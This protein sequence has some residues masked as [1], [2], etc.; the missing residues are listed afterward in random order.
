ML[1]IY[2][3]VDGVIYNINKCALDIASEEFGLT[4]EWEKNDDWWWQG[5]NMTDTPPPREYF[6]KLLNRKGFFLNGEAVDGAIKGV[7]EL[8]DYGFDIKFITAPHWSS[9]Y[10][11]H[12]RMEWL[13]KNFNWFKKE[14]HLILTSNK[15]VCDKE[16]RVLIDDYPHNLNW[17]DGLNICFSQTYN[18]EYNGLRVEDWNELV[19]YL[20][21]L[22]KEF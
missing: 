14:K 22:E 20:I 9:P 11:I 13:E 10:M 2:L 1:E 3:D 21:E 19:K 5:K 12:E 7:N 15:K 6:E 4:L 17:I 16:D 8:H 18:R